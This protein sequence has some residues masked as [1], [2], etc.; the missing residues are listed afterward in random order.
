MI[1]KIDF[2]SRNRT[3]VTI[4]FFCFKLL[5]ISFKRLLFVLLCLIG[6]SLS[7]FAQKKEALPCIE[8]EFLVLA[9]IVNDSLGK[10]NIEEPLITN[11][12]NS[13]NGYFS[14]ICVSFQLCEFRYID[15]FQYDT[16][17]NGEEDNELNAKYHERFR[18]NIFFIETY[19]QEPDVCGRGTLGGVGQL[20]TGNV[21]MVK[22][23]TSPGDLTIVH[24]MG[25]FFGLPHT[26]EGSG[27]E[28]VDGSNCET[29]GDKICDTPADP[30]VFGDDASGY[31][32]ELD[33]IEFI[34][35][36]K[37]ANGDFYDP[38]TKNIMSYYPGASRFTHGQY[39][40]M[41]ETYLSSNPKTW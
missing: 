13:L 28:L 1:L 22:K 36:R 21:Y 18:I 17:L 40:K 9:H 24:E 25:H 27:I 6:L 33:I 4:L 16:L 35:E 38:D 7:S 39:L 31:V 5:T 34:D 14:E 3:F 37:D 2:L 23:C 11:A 26:F 32:N 20:E 19:D 12:V 10:S 29:A 15:N 30:F 8:K 41:A